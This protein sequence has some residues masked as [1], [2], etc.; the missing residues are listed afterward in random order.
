M[1]NSDRLYP[2]RPLA[3][4][5][6]FRSYGTWLPGDARG[7][8]NRF[9]NVIGEP[10]MP[11]NERRHAF[12][13]ARMNREPVRL[14][15]EQRRATRMAIHETCEIRGWSLI[16]ENV[17]TNHVH[18]VVA[19][20]EE[21]KR[22]AAVLKANATRVMREMGCWQSEESPWSR[23]SSGR[24]VFSERGLERVVRYVADGQGGS[25]EDVD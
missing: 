9:T 14:N 17:R 15:A 1:T 4:F 8:V 11:P 25:L 22:L 12:S 18:V 19:G 23:G 7:S 2:E 3:T 24:R 16:A 5:I 21:P 10:R 6:T 13:R 20:D